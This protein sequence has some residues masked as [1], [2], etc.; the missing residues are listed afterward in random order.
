MVKKFLLCFISI[1]LLVSGALTLSS[2][3]KPPEYAE[4]EERFIE[5][6]EEQEIEQ[7]KKK[8]KVFNNWTSRLTQLLLGK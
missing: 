6:V 2:C 1:A 3:S 5:L 8:I 7:S 4:I